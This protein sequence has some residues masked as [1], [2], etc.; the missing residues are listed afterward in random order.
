MMSAASVTLVLSEG[1]CSAPLLLPGRGSAAGDRTAAPPEAE[2]AP[3]RLTTRVVWS[4]RS[5]HVTEHS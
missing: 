1:E 3:H 2:S 5:F 4:L